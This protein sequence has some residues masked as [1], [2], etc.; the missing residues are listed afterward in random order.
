MRWIVDVSSLEGKEPAQNYCVEAESWQ[1]ALQ[2][3]RRLRGDES[4][5]AGFSIDIT[6]DGCKAVDPSKKL[7]YEVKRT[8]DATPLTP[9]AEAPAPSKRRISGAPPR[10]EAA[11]PAKPQKPEP[12]KPAPKMPDATV[13][14]NASAVAEVEPPP[15]APSVAKAAPSAPATTPMLAPPTPAAMIA[16]PPIL[17]QREQEPTAEVPLTYREYG[18][19]FALGHV[20]GSRGDCAPPAALAHSERASPLRPPASS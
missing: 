19:A 16:I 1:G 17:V 3:A 10:P 13:K 12:P 20:G 4:R 11:P 15:S 6:N 18:F 5:M 9:G 14:M 7:R 2:S 8:T